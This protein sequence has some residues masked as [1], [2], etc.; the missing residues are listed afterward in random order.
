MINEEVESGVVKDEVEKDC[1]VL[2]TKDLIYQAIVS[3]LCLDCGREPL[4]EA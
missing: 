3:E 4:K 2:N 1:W